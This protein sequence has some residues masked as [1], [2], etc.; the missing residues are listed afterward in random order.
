MV[1]NQQSGCERPIPEEGPILLWPNASGQERRTLVLHVSVCPFPGCP[2]RHVLVDGFLVED[3]QPDESEPD[4]AFA[5]SV[6]VDAPGEVRVERCRDA[7]AL[8]WFTDALDDELRAALLRRFERLRSEADAPLGD[9]PTAV[10]SSDL[11]E[12]AG[13]SW[14]A[15]AIPPDRLVAVLAAFER[16]L[17]RGEAGRGRP[18]R[19][20]RVGRND[21]CPCGSGKKYKRCCLGSA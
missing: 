20:A 15:R 3:G 14:T 17:R 7:T 2:E 8:R 11:G 12:V 10:G 16:G 21:A 9:E 18:V 1:A 4:P 5:A 19:A 13:R 6:D